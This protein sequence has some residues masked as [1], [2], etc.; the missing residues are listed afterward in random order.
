MLRHKYM[1]SAGIMHI[2]GAF[3]EL[4]SVS[5]SKIQKTIGLQSWQSHRPSK[6]EQFGIILDKNIKN[7]C[8]KLLSRKKDLNNLS[9]S[10]LKEWV[11]QQAHEV[12]SK[13]SKFIHSF[14]SD[15]VIEISKSMF[16]SNQ[17]VFIQAV[18]DSLDLESLVCN[19]KT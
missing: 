11:V 9:K 8:V 5:S 15:L 1:Q 18:C 6:E 4:L 2:R 10:D 16:T 14:S 3:E 12:Y 19:K 7:F 17:I 13:E